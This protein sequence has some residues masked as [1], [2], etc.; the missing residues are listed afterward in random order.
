MNLEDKSDATLPLWSIGRRVSKRQEFGRE[1]CPLCALTESIAESVSA[2]VAC[3]RFTFVQSRA[4]KVTVSL[5]GS[6]IPT[7]SPTIE[8]RSVEVA[9]C[10]FH[11]AALPSS[12]RLFK[13]QVRL[14]SFPQ[15]QMKGILCTAQ[16]QYVEDEMRGL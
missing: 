2:I 14:R 5:R 11:F 7:G 10:E 3:H 8:N 4:S 15:H 12:L 6:S 13:R 9:E 16:I 1:L